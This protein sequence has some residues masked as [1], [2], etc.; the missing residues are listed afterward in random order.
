MALYSDIS[1]ALE[2]IFIQTKIVLSKY[3]LITQ[4]IDNYKSGLETNTR[5]RL[6]KSIIRNNMYVAK[7]KFQLFFSRNC[8]NI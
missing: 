4:L 6:S 5:Y 8:I 2:F 3:I 1:Y 7:H